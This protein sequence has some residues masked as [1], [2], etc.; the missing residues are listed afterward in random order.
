VQLTPERAAIHPA[1]SGPSERPTVALVAH[2]V[3]EQGGMERACAEL[4]RRGSASYRFV[5]ISSELG[6]ELRDLVVWERVPV[7]QR[8]FALKF[9]TFAV[10][11]GLRLRRSSVDLVHTVGAIVPNRVDIAAVHFCHAGFRQKTGSLVPPGQTL[12]RRGNTVIARFLALIAERWSYRPGRLKT[13]AAV[14]IGVAN[15]LQRDY[16]GIPVRMAPNGIDV[17]RFR[18]DQKVRREVRNELGVAPTDLVALFLGGDWDRK[19]LA[20]AIEGIAKASATARRPLSLWVV[21]RGDER[22]FRAIA[23]RSG[24]AD[25]VRFFGLRSD[26]ER[27]FQASDVFVLPTLYETFSLAAFEAAASTVPVVAPAVSGIDELIGQ[28]EAGIVVERTSESVGEAIARLAV[29]ADLRARMGAIGRQ[30]ASRYTWQE[31]V[32]AILAAYGDLLGSQR[33]VRA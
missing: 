22:R 17:D 20:I 26:P 7:P 28:N 6:S 24:I 30:R 1:A 23:E 32:E 18:P 3:H 5:V 27:F 31:S 4:V 14:S 33:R 2:N 10:R 16:P 25:H 8:P 12:L 9:L 21:G 11:A 15:E 19:G 13:F 29:D